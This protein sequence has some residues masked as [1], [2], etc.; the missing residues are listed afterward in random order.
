MHSFQ[1]ISISADGII[2]GFYLASVV[3]GVADFR[4]LLGAEYDH[5]D[6]V[7]TLHLAYLKIYIG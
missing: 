3:F 6:K 4:A 7:V 5:E 1:I 2:S